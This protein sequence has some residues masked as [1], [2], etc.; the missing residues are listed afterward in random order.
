MTII[1]Y[2]PDWQQQWDD[3]VRKSKN[4]T[5]LF[6]RGYMDYHA[7]RFTDHSLLFTH[8]GQLCALLPAT[9]S[10]NAFSSH[11]G[12][13]Y[14]GL[15]T[16]KHIT[17]AKVL[18]AFILLKDYLIAQG[19]QSFSYKPI[20]HIYHSIPAEEDLYAL[21][22]IGAKL[23]ARGVSSTIYQSQPLKLPESR[24]SGLRKAVRAGLIVEN[25]LDFATFWNILN[26]NLS[27]RYGVTAVH[28]LDEIKLL[29]SR[30]PDEIKLYVAKKND[31]ILA[32]V[33]VY[34][35]PTVAHTQYIAA[36]PIG[37]KCGA[38]DLIIHTLITEVYKS[39]R[40]FDFGISTEHGGKLLNES[41][42]YQKEGFG[43]RATCYDTYSLDLTRF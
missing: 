31:D 24:K 7:D 41:L 39:W 2:T 26:T 40:F 28:S 25:T 19:L 29:A 36:S 5:F 6:C 22:R 30:F 15:I 12:L 27:N 8:N 10:G 3:F 14:G 33:L 35:T 18:E 4:G 42:I 13:T 38:L 34:I 20:P 37:K 21:F 17:A 23:T 1:R 43:G 16:D 32:G 9:T 11:S